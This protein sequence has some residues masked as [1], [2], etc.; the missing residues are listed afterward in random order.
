MNYFLHHKR[1]RVVSASLLPTK[2]NY[3]QE[4]LLIGLLLFSVESLY[5]NPRSSADIEYQYSSENASTTFI[6]VI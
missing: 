5:E 4:I 3:L 6:L 2:L 1:I